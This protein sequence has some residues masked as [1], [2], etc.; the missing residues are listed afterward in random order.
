MSAM[1]QPQATQPGKS[2]SGQATVNHKDTVLKI[3]DIVNRKLDNLDTVS[4]RIKA[5]AIV[6]WG[7]IITQVWSSTVNT[8]GVAVLLVVM[9]TAL[10]LV[11]LHYKLFHE[12]FLRISRDIEGMLH[13]AVIDDHDLRKVLIKERLSGRLTI[14][15]VWRPEVK[16]ALG[17][18]WVHLPYLLL[19]IGT[20]VIFWFNRLS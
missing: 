8:A 20:A 15:G 12:Q 5:W 10:W 18:Y 2:A 17:K 4:I 16:A 3:Y 14:E 6:L 19:L 13:R 9:L 11:D 7:A 1:P